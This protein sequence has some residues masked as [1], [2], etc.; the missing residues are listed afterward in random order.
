VNTVPC[1]GVRLA[2]ERAGRGPVLVL[3]HGSWTDRRTWDP[4]YTTLANHFTVIRYDRRGY[5]ASEGPGAPSSV[6]AADLLALIGTLGVDRVI[7]VGNSLGALIAMR[8]ALAESERVGLVFSHEAPLLTLLESDPAHRIIAEQKRAAL[9]RVKEAILA[10]D[11]ALGA[12]IFVESASTVPG[13]WEP[14]P[15]ATKQEF[16][17]N[18]AAFLAEADTVSDRDFDL[19]TM[20]RLGN[21]LVITRGDRSSPYLRIISDEL[22]KLLPSAQRHVFSG[23]G[24]VPH[25]VCP[26]D[27]VLKTLE[28]VQLRP[29]ED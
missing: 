21:R 28:F 2:V 3:V 9:A 14:L 19:G 27:F 10:G 23:A 11:H 16:V 25:R 17:Q 18:A 12:K 4:V 6:H 22:C 29:S 8:A 24:H 13:A 7:Y 20:A 26:N 1:N 5:G 15:D